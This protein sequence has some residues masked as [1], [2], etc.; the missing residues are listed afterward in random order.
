M[1][2]YILPI[3][4]IAASL[5]YL[6]MTSGI[7]TSTPVSKSPPVS[8]VPNLD[9]KPQTYTAT[10]AYGGKKHK[11]KNKKSNTKKYKK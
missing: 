7:G 8:Y 3:M 2:S 1:S 4:G 6:A 11:S 9:N 10:A 5:G